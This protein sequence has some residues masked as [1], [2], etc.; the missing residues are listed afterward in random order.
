MSALKYKKINERPKPRDLWIE[1]VKASGREPELLVFDTIAT[2][3]RSHAATPDVVYELEVAWIDRLLAAGHPLTNEPEPRHN[4]VRRK[5]KEAD[6]MERAVERGR[7][8]ALSLGK[9]HR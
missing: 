8:L 6:L 4:R 3:Q 1:S 7:N 9:G 5:V 2:D